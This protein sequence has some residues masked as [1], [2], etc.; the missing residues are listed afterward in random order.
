[1]NLKNALVLILCLLP[2]AALLS[3]TQELKDDARFKFSLNY[4][5]HE[6]AIISVDLLSPRLGQSG[7]LGINLG[8]ANHVQLD[9]E[10]RERTLPI[11]QYA[12]VWRMD[13]PLMP[14]ENGMWDRSLDFANSFRL[15]QL[16]YEH[17]EETDVKRSQFT[18]V[19]MDVLLNVTSRPKNRRPDAWT[20]S[21]SL[22]IGT[23]FRL[24]FIGQRTF[25]G[26]SEVE[27]LRVFPTLQ[28]AAELF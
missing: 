11:T 6:K 3:Q 28:V 19:E 12:V 23:G 27:S 15:G 4:T 2:S 8:N 10:D 18:F 13:E 24:N 14:L 17:W 21:T 20:K 16:S 7:R 26:T 5:Q 1:M 25:I 22:G 9:D